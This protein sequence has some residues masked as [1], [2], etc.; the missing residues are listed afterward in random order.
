LVLSRGLTA[1]TRVVTEGATEIWGVEY[2][3]IEED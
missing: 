3:G 1:G 2:G